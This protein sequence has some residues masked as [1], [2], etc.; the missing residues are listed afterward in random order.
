MKEVGSTEDTEMFSE[1]VGVGKDI[2]KEM[3][4]KINEK[5]IREVRWWGCL[6]RK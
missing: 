4:V 6:E 5:S 2:F 3:S 1:L